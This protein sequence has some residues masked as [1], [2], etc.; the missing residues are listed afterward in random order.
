MS[1]SPRASPPQEGVSAH[2]LHGLLRDRIVTCDL[3]PGQRISESELAAE[4]NVSRQ[5]VRET[6]I[7]LAEEGLVVVRPQRGTFVCRISVPAALTTRFIREAVEADLVRRVAQR[8]TPEIIETLDAEITAQRAVAETG[9]PAEFMRLDETFHRLLAEFAGK[10]EVSDYLQALN[11]QINRVRNISA[12]QFAPGKL[13]REHAAIVEPIRTG[14]ASAAEDA[15]RLHLRGLN[16]DLPKI[17]AANPD[18]FEGT[19]AIP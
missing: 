15:M 6:F 12:R 11:V 4:Y 1:T 19:D 9:T 13:V 8:V 18:Y 17:V 10:L 3:A 2:Q 5:P 14:D 16:K 7:K